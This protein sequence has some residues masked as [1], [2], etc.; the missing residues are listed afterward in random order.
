MA[1]ATIDQATIDRIRASFI[2]K[3][4]TIINH[5]KPW[6]PW[7]LV[8]LLQIDDAD[9]AI[10]AELMLYKALKSS[11]ANRMT[12]RDPIAQVIKKINC[13]DAHTCNHIII[14]F[15]RRISFLRSLMVAQYITTTADVSPDFMSD[16]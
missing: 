1:S 12:I 7:A 5:S 9:S 15:R 2:S 6:T 16:I 14:Y 3:R 13:S 10:P 4:E 8:H 11:A